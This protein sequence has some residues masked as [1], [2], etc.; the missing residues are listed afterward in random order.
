METNG[1]VT[2]AD[3]VCE[4]TLH[5]KRR[6]KLL[7]LVNDK[8]GAYQ[9]G[10]Y[11][12][13]VGFEKTMD[14]KDIAAL[15]V[16][17][18]GAY[19]TIPRFTWEVA[20]YEVVTTTY[21]GRLVKKVQLKTVGTFTQFPVRLGWALTAHKSQGQDYESCNIAKPDTFWLDGQLY[22]ALSRAKSVG[23]LYLGK[24]LTKGMVKASKAV[25]D[26]FK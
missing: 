7:I 6:T 22:V 4:P 10:T 12:E 21:K 15:R 5:L 14:G 8:E 2:E 20:R 18:N 25:T 16:N 17:V 11:G 9:N 24:K 26:F 23:T 3:I 1:E 19:V 13:L